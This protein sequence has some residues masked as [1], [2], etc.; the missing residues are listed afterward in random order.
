MERNAD[1]QAHRE[2]EDDDPEQSVLEVHTGGILL[3]LP[4]PPG[5]AFGGLPFGD[6]SG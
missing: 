4:L 2:G 6:A 1:E 5:G 3:H